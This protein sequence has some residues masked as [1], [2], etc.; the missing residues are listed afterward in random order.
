VN[1][2]VQT[3][4]HHKCDPRL[5]KGYGEKLLL[6]LLATHLGFQETSV[7][8]KRAVQFGARTAKMRSGKEKGTDALW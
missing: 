3:P 6:R 4:I 2:L 8:E 5:P 7:R 1:C